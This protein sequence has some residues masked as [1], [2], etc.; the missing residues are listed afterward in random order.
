[1]STLAQVEM[2]PGEYIY[3]SVVAKTFLLFL[4]AEMTKLYLYALELHFSLALQMERK[5]LLEK[6][7]IF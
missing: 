1:M 4:P 2:S 6:A 3:I 7:V 5:L